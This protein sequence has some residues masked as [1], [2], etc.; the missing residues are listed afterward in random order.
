MS[1]LKIEEDYCIRMLADLV[2]TAEVRSI[3]AKMLMGS[4]GMLVK[5][6]DALL[7]L[8]RKKNQA[9]K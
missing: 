3:Q 5:H 2:D 7:A 4:Y 9:K 8:K 1:L 6:Y